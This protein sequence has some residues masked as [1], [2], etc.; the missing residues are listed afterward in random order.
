MLDKQMSHC[1]MLQ[2]KSG[3]YLLILSLI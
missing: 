1:L 3:T 2:V